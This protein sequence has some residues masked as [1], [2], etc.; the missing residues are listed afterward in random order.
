MEQHTSRPTE[1]RARTLPSISKLHPP[2]SQSPTQPSPQPPYSH[3][4]QTGSAYPYH[5]PPAY[6]PPPPHY[7]PPPSRSD[8]PVEHGHAG[9][10]SGHGTPVNRQPPEYPVHAPQ[11]TP[12]T[13]SQPPS[14]A[15]MRHPSD[16]P[17]E[18]PPPPPQQP[19]QYH[20]DQPHPPP[21]PGHQPG[22]YGPAPHQPPPPQADPGAPPP[23]PMIE[24]SPYAMQYPSQYPPVMYHPPPYAAPQPQTK[25][26]SNRA[27]QACDR[28]RER[29]SKCDEQH[30][31]AT[32]AEQG[33]ECKYRESQATKALDKSA[34]PLLS[35][36]HDIVEQLPDTSKE[37][38][39]KLSR[40]EELLTAQAASRETG[41]EPKREEIA[42]TDT[43]TAEAMNKSIPPSQPLP[44]NRERSFQGG[45]HHAPAPTPTTKTE[46]AEEV[47][48]FDEHTTAAHKLLYL[49]PSI[50]NLFERDQR[51]ALRY[52]YVLH[53][54]ARGW[55]RLDGA[56]EAQKATEFGTFDA[57]TDM[58]A[59]SPPDLW[60]HA[61]QLP[62]DPKGTYISDPARLDL[63]E[64]TVMRLLESY[65]KHIHILHPFLDMPTLYKFIQSFVKRHASPDSRTAVRSPRVAV[66][67]EVAPKS[68]KRKRDYT[69]HQTAASPAGQSRRIANERSLPVAITYLVLAL[70]SICEYQ[71]VVPGPLFDDTHDFS[72]PPPSILYSGSPPATSRPSPAS[73][74]ASYNAST[75]SSLDARGLGQSPQSMHDSPGPGAPRRP[76]SNVE[77]I[78]G[79]TY[80]REACT[81]LGL[82]SDSSELAVAQA[83]LLAGLYKGQ[84]GRVQESW[85][86]IH[87]A[88]NLCRYHIRMHGFDK[89][90]AANYQWKYPEGSK[91]GIAENTLLL[92]CWSALQLES[93]ILAEL[94]YPHS[95]LAMFQSSIPHPRHP[96]NS[97]SGDD[98]DANNSLKSYLALLTLRKWL[99]ETHSEL[100]G[101]NLPTIEPTQLAQILDHNFKILHLFRNVHKWDDSEPPAGN[102]LEA[103]KRAKYYGAAYIRLR[104]YLD[105]VLHAKGGVKHGR[106]PGDMARDAYGRPR[107]NEAALFGAIATLP[108]DVVTYRA[109][110]CVQ[111]AIQSTLA[112]DGIKGRLIVTNIMGTSH[113]QFSNMVVLAACYR[114]GIDF[115]T[116]L[117][118]ARE[119]KDLFVRTVRFL[120]Q[121]KYCSPTANQDIQYLQMIHRKLFR[122]DI[123]VPFGPVPH[124]PMAADDDWRQV[125][126]YSHS[127]YMSAGGSFESV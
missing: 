93:D 102:I 57:D 111:S 120:S 106:H 3:R 78:P 94:D 38:L 67:G 107:K 125:Q 4:S 74:T 73:T 39:D 8:R 1:Q 117:V 43:P 92:V 115:L 22:Y 45:Q 13:P 122:S 47:L 75:P 101:R 33:V 35:T 98:E 95:G 108:D 14:S 63:S 16:R 51:E 79:L 60:E 91:Q 87:D 114:S 46:Q 126:T 72:M 55:L 5:Q 26:K 76:R 7:P 124:P 52:N 70:G 18:G 19:P 69:G 41:R 36:I 121:L 21:P 64:K 96:Q 83:R 116:D 99:N 2:S 123:P 37:I 15:S 85:T 80:Y 23:H 113:A 97:V 84:L 53:G 28:C 89:G 17:S 34:P 119:L 127:G 40:L 59:R 29:K 71:G 58:E 110:L 90:D 48:D 12:S 109:T 66:N 56:G 65:C 31:C 24:H 118:P 61:T 50:H 68:G 49:W 27:A 81:I 32:C 104:P 25:K 112:F 86:W 30:P 77:Q 105:Y 11:R 103:R 44:L 62:T 6:A 82:F 42:R 20:H 9:E 88:C 10:G 100:Y 54:E